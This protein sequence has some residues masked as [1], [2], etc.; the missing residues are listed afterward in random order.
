MIYNMT[1]SVLVKDTVEI[2][3]VIKRE[4]EAAI[5]ICV[6]GDDFWIPFSQTHSIHREDTGDKLVISKWIAQKKG[7]Y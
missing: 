1:L 4:T 5:C 7:L 6:D 3:G 2:H